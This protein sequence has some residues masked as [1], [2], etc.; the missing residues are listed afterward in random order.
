MTQRTRVDQTEAREQNTR[1]KVTKD[2]PG[3]VVFDLVKPAYGPSRIWT[4]EEKQA[5]SERM[6]KAMSSPETREKLR[7]A[8]SGRPMS[9]ETKQKIREKLQG[10][11][12]S[13]EQ[14]EKIRQSHLRRHA[15]TPEDAA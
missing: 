12:M 10:R 13:E 1:Q 9:E 14:K 8:N 7:K 6:Q 2:T 11:Q 3:A 15:N 5:H 4:D